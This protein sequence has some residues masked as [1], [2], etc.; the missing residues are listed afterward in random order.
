V[1]SSA[2]ADIKFDIERDKDLKQITFEVKPVTGI[3]DLAGALKGLKLIAVDGIAAPESVAAVSATGHSATFDGW[4]ILRYCRDG[5]TTLR[6][7]GTN[8]TGETID[9]SIQLH[10]KIKKK[11]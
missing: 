5:Q 2:S 4:S 6:F 11:G 10:V 1:G 9:G 7:R 3:A 8:G